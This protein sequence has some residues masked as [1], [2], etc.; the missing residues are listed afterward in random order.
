LLSKNEKIKDKNE[1]NKSLVYTRLLLFSLEREEGGHGP[2]E[3]IY[4]K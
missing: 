1:N 3:E 2:T 4:P